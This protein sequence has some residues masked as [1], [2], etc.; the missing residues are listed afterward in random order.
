MAIQLTR[1]NPVANLS[2]LHSS[3]IPGPGLT[4][5][6]QAQTFMCWISGDANV[7]T[8]TQASSICGMYDGT[9]DASTLPTTALQIGAKLNGDGVF[10]WTWGGVVLVSTSP[11]SGNGAI[12]PYTP[13]AN[14]WF[15][16]VY[17]CNTWTGTNQTHLMYINGVLRASSTNI[18]QVDGQ[19]TQNFI[20]GYPQVIPVTGNETANVKVDDVRLYNR[21]LTANEILTIYNSYGS[22]DDIV[23]GLVAHYIFEESI[24]GLPTTNVYDCSASVNNLRMQNYGG[25]AITYCDGVT[26]SNVRVPQI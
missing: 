25:T 9:Y 23:S 3:N 12:T 6:R 18:L 19:F 22:I 5:A 4:T 14:I 16:V 21:Q 15:H 26:G 20:N 8:A 11:T 24:N 17:A 1:A 2:F 10:L 13:T 7:W